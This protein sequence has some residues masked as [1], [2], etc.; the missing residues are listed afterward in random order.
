MKDFRDNDFVKTGKMARVTL[1]GWDGKSYDGE[2]RNLAVF[3]HPMHPGEEFIRLM[4]RGSRCYHR[5]TD[6]KHPISGETEVEFYTY[7]E[8]I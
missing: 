7:F 1:G 8:S 5:I 2:A 4:Y 6:R 3:V